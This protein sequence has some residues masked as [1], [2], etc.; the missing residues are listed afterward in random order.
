ML[1]RDRTKHKTKT[2]GAWQ[3]TKVSCLDSRLEKDHSKTQ[4]LIYPCKTIG[5]ESRKDLGCNVLPGCEL[6][7]TLTDTN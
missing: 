7:I 6:W 4:N 5:E 3:K 1:S 2:K